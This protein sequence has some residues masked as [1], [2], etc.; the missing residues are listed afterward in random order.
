M[1]AVK[2]SHGAC[3]FCLACRVNSPSDGND[4]GSPKPRKSRLASVPIAP[5]MI[6]GRKV[7]VATIAFGN[8]W[9]NMMVRLETPK[10]RAA[11]TYSKFRALRNSARTTPTRPVQP[12]STIRNTSSQ[13]F[14]RTNAAMMMMT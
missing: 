14:I 2:P 12:N 4:D 8:T 7:R 3:R 13:K 9:R 10:A 6:K 11:R 5:V 1:K